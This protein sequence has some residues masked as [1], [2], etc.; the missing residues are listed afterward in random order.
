MD[1]WGCGFCNIDTV[2]N[3]APDC[4]FYKETIIEK[5]FGM[6]SSSVPLTKRLLEERNIDTAK[7]E[8]DEA[9]TWAIRYKKLYE[10]AEGYRHG[11]QVQSEIE[12]E[13]RKQAEQDSDYACAAYRDMY[14]QWAK[15]ERECAGKW[16]EVAEWKDRA[17]R[18]EEHAHELEALAERENAH[19][20]LCKDA[21]EYNLCQLHMNECVIGERD[22]KAELE[23]AEAQ[24]DNLQQQ[25]DELVKQLENSDRWRENLSDAWVELKTQN[26]ELDQERGMLSDAWIE[27]HEQNAELLEALK[28]MVKAGPG[29][30]G[31]YCD[32]KD[33]LAKL[34]EV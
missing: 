11:W 31:P 5:T 2:G 26:A 18:W 9:R 15:S 12:E 25:R 8:R 28:A 10:Y 22:L 27:L 1:N 29:D 23:K 21:A 17:Q 32:A 14:Q 3:H 34:D 20:D 7:E 24:R 4:P 6:Y 16:F 19:C 33:L 30:D 13:L